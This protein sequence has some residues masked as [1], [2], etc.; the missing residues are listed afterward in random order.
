MEGTGQGQPLLIQGSRPA[1]SPAPGPGRLQARLRSLADQVPLEL[2]QGTEDVEDELAA[3]GGRVDRFPQA[4]E[5]DLAPLEGGDRPDQV[6]ERASQAIELPDDQGIAR[7]EEGEGLRQ[8][9]AIILGPAGHVGEGPLAAGLGEGVAL[10]VEVLILGRD[11]GV[12]DE[13]A[14]LG[15]RLHARASQNSPSRSSFDTLISRRVMRW[16]W[17]RL[18]ADS[19]ARAGRLRNARF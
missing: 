1:P 5:A 13:H 8:A 15:W 14:A 4:A 12:A 16:G 7:A 11:A 3:A 19:G 18:R 6:L 9:G 10:Q 2:R 17:R